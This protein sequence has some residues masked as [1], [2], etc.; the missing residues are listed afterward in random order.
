[1]VHFVFSLL[2]ICDNS[3][4]TDDACEVVN[5]NEIE[6]VQLASDQVHHHY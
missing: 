6:E 5:E 3:E 4:C 1:M 2:L